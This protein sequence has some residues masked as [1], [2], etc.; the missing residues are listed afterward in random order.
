MALLRILYYAQMFEAILLKI[1]FHGCVYFCLKVKF[2]F[3]NNIYFKIFRFPL[4]KCQMKLA[5]DLLQISLLC[6]IIL[7]IRCFFT[8]LT[9]YVYICM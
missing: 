7:S 6:E 2:K 9:L 4:I 3:L 8:K 5:S 1:L